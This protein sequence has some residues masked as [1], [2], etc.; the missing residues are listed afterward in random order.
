MHQADTVRLKHMLDYANFHGGI[1]EYVWEHGEPSREWYVAAHGV[2]LAAFNKI[3]VRV[4]GDNLTI[5]P[6]GDDADWLKT[7]HVENLRLPGALLLS[8]ERENGGECRIEIENCANIERTLS[9]RLF[10]GGNEVIMGLAAGEKK[11][12]SLA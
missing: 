1:P 5:F 11:T 4:D 2:F 10:C 9:V 12:I 7:I 3:I 6:V 8:L